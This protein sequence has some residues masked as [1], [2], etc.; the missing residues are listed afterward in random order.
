MKNKQMINYSDYGWVDLSNL[1]MRGKRVWWEK[2]IGKTIEFQYNDIRSTILISEYYNNQKVYIDINGYVS[3]YLVNTGSIINVRL[4]N[5]LKAKQ[6]AKFIYNIGDIINDHLLIT[7]RYRDDKNRKTYGYKCLI[8]GYCGIKTEQEFKNHKN[9]PVCVGRITLSG[10]NDIATTHPKFVKYFK[11][12]DDTLKYSIRSGKKAWFKCPDCGYEK[13]TEIFNAFRNGDRYSCSKCGDNIS[14]ANKF[15]YSFLKQIQNKNDFS[16]EP[17]KTFEWSKKINGTRPRRIYDFYLIYNTDIIIEAHGA[18]HYEDG[19]FEYCGGRTLVEEQAND[20]FKYNLAI[21]NGIKPENYVVIDCRKSDKIFIKNS[22]MSSILPNIFNFSENDIDW[23]ECD[24]YACSNLIKIACNLWNGGIH[25]ASEIA[26]IMNKA[27]CTVSAY[28]SKGHNLG[29]VEYEPK[30]KM[31]VLCLDNGYVFPYST[32][33]SN[34]SE[35]LFGIFINKKCII[36]NLCGVNASTHGFHFK[37]I[38]RQ[39]YNRIKKEEPWRVFE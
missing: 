5:I 13:Y 12:L 8:D 14:Y 11:N 32:I 17:E 20:L 33:C 10:Y 18:Q 30:M 24:K 22:I 39:E 16:F 25:N 9:C 6:Y 15:I 37:H 36:N 35:S 38:T 21:Q 19:G 31:P 27:S 1:S 28:L 4:G 2:S 29:W 26:R 34:Y 7:N 3:H 23:N